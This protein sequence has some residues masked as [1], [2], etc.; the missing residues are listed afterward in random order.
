VHDTLQAV[1]PQ[2]LGAQLTDDWV[3]HT[4]WPLQVRAVVAIFDVHM[5]GAH[6]VPLGQF[7]HWP[8]PSQNPSNWQLA[9]AEGAHS[10]SGSLPAGM[11]PQVPEVDKPVFSLTQALHFPPQELL[12]QTPSAQNVLAHST[13][14]AHWLPR[15]FLAAQVINPLSQ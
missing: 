5:A 8:L 1:V 4:P 6:S 15:A 2:V 10:L 14:K 3:P 13:A 7:R 9:A 12:Q 11:A